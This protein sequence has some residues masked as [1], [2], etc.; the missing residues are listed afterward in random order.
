MRSQ[1]RYVNGRLVTLEVPPGAVSND[2]CSFH[3]G[4]G[5]GDHTGTRCR[6]V[7]DAQTPAR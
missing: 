3:H 6:L 7:F 4:A 5:E 2:G 1:R